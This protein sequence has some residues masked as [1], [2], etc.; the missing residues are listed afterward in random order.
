MPST[1]RAES[2]C[3]RRCCAARSLASFSSRTVPL[4]TGI[5]Q[6][7]TNNRAV[8]REEDGEEGVT[9]VAAETMTGGALR[10]S[11]VAAAGDKSRPQLTPSF[12]VF[13]RLRL[14]SLHDARFFLSRDDRDRGCTGV[15]GRDQRS[16]GKAEVAYVDTA[17]AE[18]HRGAF[19][20][21]VRLTLFAC[22]VCAWLV[23]ISCESSRAHRGLGDAGSVG[24]HHRGLR[25]SQ[26]H[27]LATQGSWSASSVPFC[28]RELAL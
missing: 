14:S 12:C 27:S 2:R 7:A 15:L 8:V 16:G 17:T 21:L 1:H 5:A 13:C 28:E 10:R 4:S 11:S 20:G 24:S 26:L 25:G 19:T 22:Y 6:I 18:E 9:A 3:P 23:L